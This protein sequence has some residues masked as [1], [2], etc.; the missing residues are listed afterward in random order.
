MPGDIYLTD[1]MGAEEAAG[2]ARTQ[3]FKPFMLI[4]SVQNGRTWIIIRG[5]D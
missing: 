3:S 2:I 4:K 5:L 1:A